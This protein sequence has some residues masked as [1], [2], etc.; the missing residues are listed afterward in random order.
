MGL[1]FSRDEKSGLTR[2][3]RVIGNQSARVKL[4]PLGHLSFTADGLRI[5]PH[6]KGACRWYPGSF[7]Q[8]CSAYISISLGLLRKD[9][10]SLGDETPQRRMDGWQYDQAVSATSSCR[11]ISP[12]PQIRERQ[13]CDLN[14]QTLPLKAALTM[15][16]RSCSKSS[17]TS[18]ASISSILPSISRRKWQRSTKVFSPANV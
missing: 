6:C 13:Q 17:S 7:H 15:I 14:R 11:S 18:R 5:V 4:V 12:S 10:R 9:V 3:Y 16:F 8:I 2:N 1:P